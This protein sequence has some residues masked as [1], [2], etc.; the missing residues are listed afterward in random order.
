LL[1]FVNLI[2]FGIKMLQF[3]AYSVENRV[4]EL[5]VAIA[6][7]YEAGIAVGHRT[8]NEQM[9]VANDKVVDWVSFDIIAG[10]DHSCLVIV[11][12]ILRLAR[13]I[14]AAMRTP[15]VSKRQYPTRMY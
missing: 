13:L 5:T 15:T 6:E 12:G 2:I 10:I 8:I 11:A 3:E 14:A 9:T 7:D 4:G 1:I